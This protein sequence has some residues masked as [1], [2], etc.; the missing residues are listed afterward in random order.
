MWRLNVI[1]MSI[2]LGMVG[3]NIDTEITAQD[4]YGDEN[5]KIEIIT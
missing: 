2:E 4:I 1:Y 5:G 3:T